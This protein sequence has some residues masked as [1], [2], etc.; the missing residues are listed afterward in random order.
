MELDS[1]ADGNKRAKH[2]TLKRTVL[3]FMSKDYEKDIFGY[4][5]GGVEPSRLYKTPMKKE[6][7][8]YNRQALLEAN[9]N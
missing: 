2:R 5:A 1:L 8:Y 9:S 4:S 3:Y 7:E 6:R